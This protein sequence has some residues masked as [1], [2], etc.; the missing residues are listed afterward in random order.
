MPA[1]PHRASLSLGTR[2]LSPP[3]RLQNTYILPGIPRLFQQMVEAHADRFRG[4]A[5]IT[6]ALYT[7]MGEGARQGGGPAGAPPA[8]PRRASAA[9]S[10]AP[11]AR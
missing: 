8:F 5:A 7:N 4:P 6:A 3:P 11:R 2:T 10:L 9:P 1:R